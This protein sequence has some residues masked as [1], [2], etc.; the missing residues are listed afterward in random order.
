MTLDQPQSSALSS[1]DIDLYAVVTPLTDVGRKREHNEDNHLILPLDGGAAPQNGE[2]ATLSLKEPGL[3]LVVADGMGGYHGGEV[4]SRVCVESLAKEIVARLGDSGTGRPDLATAL[5]EAVQ[6]AHQ[7]VLAYARATADHE[8]MGTTLTAALVCGARA[9]VAQVGDSRAYLYRDG[10][11]ILLTQDQTIGNQLRRQGQDPGLVTPQIADL[12]TQAVGAQAEIKVI[13]TGIDLAPQDLLLL[14]SDGLYKAVSPEEMVNI[15]EMNIPLADRARGL[16]ARGN[17]N[18][19]PD[20][21]T[22]ILVE[23][24]PSRRRNK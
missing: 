15:L 13:M 18:G 16:I 11:L 4:A 10:S 19:G 23:L 22:V 7:A 2:A 3:L 6:V 12:L 9:D 20:N 24:N 14:C 1:Q 5:Q 8:T 21:I 17:Q